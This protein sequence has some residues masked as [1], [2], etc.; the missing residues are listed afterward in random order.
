M[1][2]PDARSLHQRL[3]W[4]GRRRELPGP[5]G[6]AAY[7][8]PLTDPGPAPLQAWIGA[9]GNRLMEGGILNALRVAGEFILMRSG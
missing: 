1:N 6:G 4:P 7:R 8:A 5:G 3:G 9:F 2:L